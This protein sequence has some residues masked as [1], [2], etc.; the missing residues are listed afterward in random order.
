MKGKR[1]LRMDIDRR[2][3]VI[4]QQLISIARHRKL[5][6]RMAEG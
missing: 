5:E 1:G 2:N 3:D 6:R 4:V